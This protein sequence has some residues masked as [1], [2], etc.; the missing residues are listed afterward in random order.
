MTFG[1]WRRLARLQA[2]LPLLA[3]GQSVGAVARHVGYQ[4]ASAFVAAFRTETGL[5]PAAYFRTQGGQAEAGR[6]GTTIHTFCSQQHQ[7]RPERDD[8]G[9]ATRIQP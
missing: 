3:N 8:L 4:T 7:P 2:A 6:E 9:A 5:T 1:R